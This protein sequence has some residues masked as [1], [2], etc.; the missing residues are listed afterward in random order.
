MKLIMIVITVYMFMVVLELIFCKPGCRFDIY[1]GVPGSGKTTFAAWI[2]KK[3]FKRGNDVYSNVAIKNA[4]ILEKSDIGKYLIENGSII[5]DEAGIDYNN[6]DFK[7]FSK[8]ETYYFKYH[9]H[10]NT[11][12]FMFSQ[13]LDMDIKL[14]KLATRIFLVKKSL[15]PFFIKRKEISKKIGI[16]K[17]TKQIIDEYNFRWFSTKLIFA[18]AL[19]KMFDTYDRKE[20]PKKKWVKYA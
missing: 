15:I 1:F 9:R 16:D 10:Y 18:P 19:W 8:E 6:R 12:V 7:K 20:L 5:L 13:D 3:Q 2:A 17:Q 14:R 11:N 4:Y